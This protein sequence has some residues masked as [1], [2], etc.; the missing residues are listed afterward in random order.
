MA[1]VQAGGANLGRSLGER[2]YKTI[3]TGFCRFCRV[4]LYPSAKILTRPAGPG[5]AS[6]RWFSV[7]ADAASHDRPSEQFSPHRRSASRGERSYE[8]DLDCH[9]TDTRLMSCVRLD[10]V[11]SLV[12]A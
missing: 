2:T 10:G 5:G 11:L 6:L 9:A 1:R 4:P 12:N 7:P 3:K 8:A